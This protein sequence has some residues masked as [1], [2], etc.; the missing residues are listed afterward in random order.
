MTRF[1]SLLGG[2]I[3]VSAWLVSLAADSRLQTAERIQT[4]LQIDVS[5]YI[6]LNYLSYFKPEHLQFYIYMQD[7]QMFTSN[8]ISQVQGSWG[9]VTDDGRNS[10]FSYVLITIFT[11]YPDIQKHFSELSTVPVDAL[12]GN[13]DFNKLVAHVVYIIDNI[14]ADMEDAEIFLKHVNEL[15][16]ITHI[17]SLEIL[18]VNSSFII[19]VAVKS[20][21]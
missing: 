4:H 9:N 16:N 13:A 2:C 7:R 5:S 11:K 12:V 6:L 18:K 10:I 8:Q 1:S 15:K 21:R 20:V 19:C 17:F 3:L 14:I